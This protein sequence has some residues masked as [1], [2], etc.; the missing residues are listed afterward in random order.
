M[1]L[2]RK[3]FVLTLTGWEKKSQFPPRHGDAYQILSD[4]EIERSKEKDSR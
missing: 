2:L 3:R 1:D 4:L